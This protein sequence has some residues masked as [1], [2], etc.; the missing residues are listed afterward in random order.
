MPSSRCVPLLSSPALKKTARSPETAEL[1]GKS[2]VVLVVV[3][4]VDLVVAVVVVVLVLV[5]VVVVVV[6]LVLDE[7]DVEVLVGVLA[8]DGGLAVVD[9]EQQN[10]FTFITNLNNTI[11]IIKVWLPHRNLCLL[12]QQQQQQRTARHC[13]TALHGVTR[14]VS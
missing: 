8:V 9:L 10:A 13:T 2:W 14:I 7:V 3:V 1:A 12:Q 11:Q 6:V 5:L 4:V